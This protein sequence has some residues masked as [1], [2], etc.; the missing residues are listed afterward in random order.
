LIKDQALAWSIG[1]SWPQ[2]I[3]AT[4]ILQSTLMAMTRA[5]RT[6]KVEPRSLLVDGN[7]KIPLPLPQQ[8]IPGGDGSVP[9]ISAA[10]IVAKT[11]RD[12]LLDHLDKRYPG[13]GFSVHKGYGTKMHLQALQ[14]LGP[15]A[16]HRTSFRKVVQ[17]AARG[18]RLWLPGI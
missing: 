8:C 15:C 5:V 12:N 13:Y 6:L 11:F 3:D 1:I 10:S 14:T 16:Q 2:E 17:T 7:Q 4:D 9:A 18:K